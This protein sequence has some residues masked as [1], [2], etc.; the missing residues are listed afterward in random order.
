MAKHPLPSLARKSILATTLALLALAPTS[1]RALAQAEETPATKAPD[2]AVA[3]AGEATKPATVEA[4]KCNCPPPC[5]A[6]PPPPPAP[7]VN[8]VEWKVQSKGGMLITSGN[9]DSKNFS[10]GVNGFRK[11]GNNK[12]ALEGGLAYGTSNATTVGNID[13]TD[14][15]TPSSPRSLTNRW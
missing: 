11:E 15:P 1:G 14:P 7:P 12:L 6:P 8:P 10:L 9:S 3:P 4:P 13:S 2:E 5:P